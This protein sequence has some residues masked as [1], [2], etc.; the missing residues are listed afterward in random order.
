[1]IFSGRSERQF[2]KQPDEIAIRLDTVGLACL[3][4]RVQIGADLRACNG[5]GE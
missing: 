2:C 4:E 3:E 1:M 5:I